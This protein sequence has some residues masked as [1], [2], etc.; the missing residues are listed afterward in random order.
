VFNIVGDS[1]GRVWFGTL[2]G[3]AVLTPQDNAYSL[4]TGETPNWVTYTPA[5]SPLPSPKV[6]AMAQD[7]AGRMYFGTEEGLAI[8]DESAPAERRWRVLLGEGP[9]GGTPAAGTPVP[10]VSPAAV[11]LAGDGPRLPDSWVEALAVGPDGR[12][13]IGTKRGLAVYDPSNPTAP[14]PVYRSNPIRRWTAMFWPPHAR[15]D[16]LADQINALAWSTDRG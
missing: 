15:L 6:H 12:V 10:T 4:G 3:A 14:L 2:G 5:N 13:W 8:L 7:K 16:V 11:A 9:A 1:K